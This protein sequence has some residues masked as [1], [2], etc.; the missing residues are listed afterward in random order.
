MKNTASSNKESHWLGLKIG[1]GNELC[2][3]LK[4]AIAF[5][6]KV[7]FSTD[8]CNTDMDLAVQ[9]HGHVSC[10]VRTHAQVPAVDLKSTPLTI[11][12]N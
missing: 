6:M 7:A 1:F 4:K 12:A 8:C 11:R 3:L 10:G 2:A 9:P 5:H